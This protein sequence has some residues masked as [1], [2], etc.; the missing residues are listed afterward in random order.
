MQCAGARYESHV[1]HHVATEA[2]AALGKPH[3]QVEK[4]TGPKYIAHRQRPATSTPVRESLRIPTQQ[5]LPPL[6]S[7]YQVPTFVIRLQ[8]LTVIARPAVPLDSRIPSIA[9]HSPPTV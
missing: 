4:I 1:I 8:T 9:R 6:V 5:P 2:N 7:L 3:M